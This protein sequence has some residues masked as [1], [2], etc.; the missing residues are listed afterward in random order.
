MCI[1]MLKSVVDSSPILFVK[2][3]QSEVGAIDVKLS[4]HSPSSR[5]FLTGNINY[6]NINPELGIF[7]DGTEFEEFGDHSKCK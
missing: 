3:G 6:Y 4:A 5:S 1:T 2:I 7:G